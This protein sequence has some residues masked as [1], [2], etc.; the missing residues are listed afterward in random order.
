MADIPLGTKGT[1]QLLVT[2]ELATNFLGSE[3]ARVF[4]TPWMIAHMELT[5]RDSVKSFLPNGFDTVGTE[6]HVRHV[7]AA[8]IGS[9]LRFF[10]E[11]IALKER[12]I[13]FRVEVRLENG[14]LV[15]E[16]THER[17]IID[18]ARFAA[19]LGEKAK[20]G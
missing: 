2:S 13:D 8:P 6:V 12:R 1:F 19:K 11:V 18:V 17:A 15:G 3:A 20:A 9:T 5:C 4:A 16:G 10:S 7:A 14:D